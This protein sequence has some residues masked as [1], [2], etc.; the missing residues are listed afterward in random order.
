[1]GKRGNSLKDFPSLQAITNLMTT[2][3]HRK[4]EAIQLTFKQV[5]RNFA[6]V[7]QHLVPGGK[8]ELIMK[9][10]D[11]PGGNADMETTMEEACFNV[12]SF[13]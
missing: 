2:L 7:F 13:V 5:S 8:A 12:V 6:E 10:S 9:M 11:T 4:Y 1:M 3:D